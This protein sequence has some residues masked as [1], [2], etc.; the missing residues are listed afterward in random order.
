MVALPETVSLG[1]GDQHL[2]LNLSEP[3]HRALLRAQVD[4]A[5]YTVLR[6]APGADTA[7]VERQENDSFRRKEPSVTASDR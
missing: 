2:R 5:G 6:V 3:A 4:R 7:G 1:G